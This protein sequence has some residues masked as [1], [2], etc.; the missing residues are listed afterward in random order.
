MSESSNKRR[1][2]RKICR[3][4]L[5]AMK[6]IKYFNLGTVEYLYKD[7]ISILLK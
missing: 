1:R 3:L 4:T 7:G 2:E 5:E 6:K